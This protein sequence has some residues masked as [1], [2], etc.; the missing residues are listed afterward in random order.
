MSNFQEEIRNDYGYENVVIIAVGQSNTSGFNS[1]FCGNSD[2]PL[3]IDPYPSLPIRDQFGESSFNEFHK[4]III[5]GHDGQYLGMITVNSVSLGVKNYILDILSE[6]YQED[7]SLLGDLNNDAEINILDI[8]FLV[9]IVINEEDYNALG[10]LNYDSSEDIAQLYKD[11]PKSIVKSPPCSPLDTVTE[12]C[13]ES[14]LMLND[15][16]QENMCNGDYLRQ[17]NEKKSHKFQFSPK[18]TTTQETE[19][20]SNANDVNNWF[21]QLENDSALESGNVIYNTQCIESTSD[22]NNDSKSRIND[23]ASEINIINAGS[24]L[25]QCQL[26]NSPATRQ[27]FK[28]VLFNNS[29]FTISSPTTHMENHDSNQ[30]SVDSEIEKTRK[31]N[32]FA[33]VLVTSPKKETYV[34]HPGRT[35]ITR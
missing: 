35:E 30:G 13:A 12:P 21:D 20:K 6:N 2:L 22:K 14:Y 23:K 24:T 34:A 9:N 16:D 32:P 33:K 27:A 5:L 29:K 10:D 26:T 11:K 4:K 8:V 18:D 17:K 3:V 1:S 28:P 25:T 15:E 19:I 7:N 31:R